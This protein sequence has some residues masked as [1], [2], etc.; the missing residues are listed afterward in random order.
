MRREVSTH[1]GQRMTSDKRSR[2]EE[3]LSALTV[4]RT[5]KFPL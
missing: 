5:N 3:M 4:T 1:E 2:V